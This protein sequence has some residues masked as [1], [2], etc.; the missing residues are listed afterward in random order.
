VRELLTGR[1]DLMLAGGVQSHTP[2]QLY[3]QFSQIQALSH[4]KIRPFQ[5]GANGILLGEGV[6]MLVLKRLA[7]AEAAETGSTR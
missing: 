1:C 2:P 3:I 5:K 7:D 6:G 4:D